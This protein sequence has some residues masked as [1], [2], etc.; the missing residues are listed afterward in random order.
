MAAQAKSRPAAD[1]AGRLA[2]AET[3]VASRALPQGLAALLD[4]WR[5]KELPELAAAIDLVSKACRKGQPAIDGKNGAEKIALW[6]KIAREEKPEDFE[7]LFETAIGRS[8]AETLTRLDELARWPRDPRLHRG[9]AEWLDHMPFRSGPFL[10]RLLELVG[11]TAD[12]RALAGLHVSM[13]EG[14]RLKRA[15]KKIRARFPEGPPVATGAEAEAIRRIAA[16][17]AD[18]VPSP[19]QKKA[20]AAAEADLLR[21]IY[22]HPE[23]DQPRLV[24]ADWLLERGNPRGELIQLQFARVRGSAPKGSATRER[25]LLDAGWKQWLGGIELRIHK[26]GMRFER[27]FADTLELVRGYGSK[28]WELPAW[29]T[30]RVL[31]WYHRRSDE[32]DVRE[33]TE[34]GWWRS[35]REILSIGPAGFVALSASPLAA[36]LEVMGGTDYDPPRDGTFDVLARFPKLD[37]L[38]YRTRHRLAPSVIAWMREP[39]ILA[40]KVKR[41]RL[42]DGYDDVFEISR[43][44]SGAMSVVNLRLGAQYVDLPVAA[45]AAMAPGSVH[46]LRVDGAHKLSPEDLATLTAACERLK[47][48]KLELPAQR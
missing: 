34:G 13:W 9:L 42:R 17:V 43:D 46:E 12:P 48:A 18:A 2:K 19:A 20:T 10:T 33:M 32:R 3:L 40:S 24:Y 4:C 15:E 31:D 14:Q 41:L 11:E 16:H 30:V 21:A 25:K 7:R 1:L 5:E 27:G 8:A 22:E 38:A 35:L 47:P 23:D 29:S 37:A 26:D 39:R 28:T 45:L 36:Q 44:A 6:T